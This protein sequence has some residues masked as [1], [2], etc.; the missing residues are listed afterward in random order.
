[1][2][3]LSQEDVAPLISIVCPQLPFEHLNPN[4]KTMWA[5]AMP[6]VKV[7]GIIQDDQSI[8]VARMKIPT[9]KG[10]SFII[11]R[12]DTDAISLTTMF[13][14]AFP[15][16]DNDA[17]KGESAWVKAKYEVSGLNDGS[18]GKACFAGTWVSLTVAEE[19]A[20]SYSFN[21]ILTPFT[22]ARPEGTLS[23]WHQVFSRTFDQGV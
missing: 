20:V 19:L 1:M 7:Q 9:P 5:Y 11:R 23:E 18:G 10:Y 4:V 8:I 16:A 22:Q 6:A 14:A 21:H 2:A 15:T 3:T 12:L 13:R 17:E